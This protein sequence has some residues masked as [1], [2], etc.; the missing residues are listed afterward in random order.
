MLSFRPS[1]LAMS[2]PK[3]SPPLAIE[4]ILVCDEMRLT[5]QQCLA[6]LIPAL[7]PRFWQPSLS[8]LCLLRDALHPPVPSPSTRVSSCYLFH[9]LPHLSRPIQPFS[10]ADVD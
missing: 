6:F 7:Q 4:P 8:L 1:S 5:K 2:R 9:C 10:S 3:V